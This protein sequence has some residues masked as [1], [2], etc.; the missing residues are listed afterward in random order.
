MKVRSPQ[1][2]TFT[3]SQIKTNTTDLYKHVFQPLEAAI[4][5]NTTTILTALLT[6]YTNLLHHWTAVLRSSQTIPSHASNT[7]NLLTQHVNSLSLTLLQASDTP[8]T[9]VAE[10]TILPFYEQ[11]RVL[12]TDNR[13]RQYIRIELPSAPLIYTLFF[14]TSLSTMSRICYILG[15]Y[16]PIF[17]RAMATRDQRQSGLVDS[18]SY[19]GNYVTTYN[20]YLMDIANCFWRS[21]GFGSTDKG[22]HACQLPRAT[23]AALT[24]WVPAVDRT[25]SLLSILSLS[26]SPLLCLQSINRLREIEDAEMEKN[27]ALETRHA[28]PVNEESLAKLGTS[29]GISLTFR[30]YRI[31][32]LETLSAKGLTGVEVLLKNLLS[33]LKPVLEARARERGTVSAS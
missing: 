12:I 23:M 25:Y 22:A 16:K 24:R 6:M 21:H 27:A 14:S 10:S 3:S 4:A 28:G 20:G 15:S 30:E 33:N 11:S 18:S 9:V 17:E 26:Y 31:N 29:G 19:D 2:Q 7:I 5:D 13:L 1:Y 32:V 8:S